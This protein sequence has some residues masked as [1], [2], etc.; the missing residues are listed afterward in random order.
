MGRP[1]RRESVSRRR[2]SLRLSDDEHAELTE[3]ARELD[4]NPS[5]F[6]REALAEA[7]SDFRERRVFERRQAQV[8]VDVD[9]RRGSDR[10]RPD[11]S[12]ET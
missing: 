9:R 1:T 11:S 3:A 6:I 10:R 12:H 7:L 2:A 4:T 5:E 8:A